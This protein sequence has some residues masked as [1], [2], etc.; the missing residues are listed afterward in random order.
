M[1]G[2]P[3]NGQ[4]FKR[5]LFLEYDFRGESLGGITLMGLDLKGHA[6]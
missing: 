5:V 1:L 6:G 2:E 4:A 3:A